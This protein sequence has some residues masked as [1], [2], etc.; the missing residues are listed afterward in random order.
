[1]NPVRLE[2][3]LE[4]GLSPGLERAGRAV[5]G[6][7]SDTGNMVR[8][9][10][11]KIT[12]A[13][14]NIRQM[15]SDIRSLSAAF[16]SATPGAARTAAGAELEAARQALKEER[17]ILRGLEGDLAR[18][19][20]AQRANSRSL[21]QQL[22][23]VREEIA[24][25]LLAYR[26][27]TDSEKQ[28]AQ[29]QELARYIDELTE[30]AGELNDTIADT[31]QAVANA[32]SDTRGLDQMAGG[33]QLVTDSFGLATAAAQ[34]LGLSEEDLIEV[35]ANLQAALVASNA[36]TSIQANLQHQSALMQG[37]AVIQARAAALAE[38][39]RTWAVGRGT[40]ATYAATAAQAVFNAVA[41]ANPYVVLAAALVTV[42][43]ALYAF[44]KGNQEAAEAEEQRQKRMEDARQ[45]QERYRQAVVDSASGQVASFLKLKR[46]WESL[47]DSFD[48]KRKFITDTKDE[49]S[50]L[51]KEISTVNDMERIFRDHTKDMLNAIVIRAELKAYET[52]I[53]SVADRMVSD[54]EKNK[55]FRYTP[56]KAGR[57]SGYGQGY[58][59]TGYMAF[60]ELTQEERAAA[61]SHYTTEAS[62]SHG[63][64]Y[65]DE[66]GARIINEMRRAAGNQAALDRQEI[67]RKA[68]E[69]EI[70]GY[71][72]D[73]FHLN[74]KLDRLMDGMPGKT[75]NP[76]TPDGRLNSS[77]SGGADNRVENE[78]K[79]AEELRRL[80]WENEQD[81]INQLADG[82]E[83]RRRLIALDYEKELAEIEQRK[84]SFA[85][86]NNEAGIK[87]VN[88]DGLTE[89]QQEE[90]DRAGELAVKNRDKSLR[91]IRVLEAQHMQEY[92]KEY[93]TY[94]Q[95]RLALSEEYDR[96]IAEASDQWERKS[97]EK[98]KTSALQNL[99][100]EAIRQSVDW[101]SVFG[102][103]GTM[104]RDQ[105]EPTIEKL[106]TIS[107][108]EEF[109]ETDLEDQQTLYELI[110]KLEEANTSW[111]NGIFKKLG[112]D[113]TSYQTAMRGYI[114]AQDKE[115]TATEA[116]AGAKERLAKAEESGDTA[117]IE[118]AKAGV[119]TATDNLTEASGKVQEFGADVQDASNSLQTSTTK[120][121]NMFNTLVSSLSGLKSGT[122]QGVGESLMGL[123]KLFNNS[124]VTNAVGGALSKGLSK[125]LGN[126][127]IGKSVA[128]ALGNS[129]L[130][131]SIISGVLSILD[132]LKDGIGPLITNLTDTVLGAV[133]GII[134]NLN[135]IN[136]GK[137]VGKSLY[138]NVTGVLTG[139]LDKITFGHSFKWFNSSNE[140]EVQ[141]A[142]DKLTERNT[143]LQGAIEKLTDEIKAGK[144]SKSVEAY[145]EAR[146]L[147]EQ[148]N[149]N[150]L[151]MAQEQ[152]RYHDSHHSF[153]YYWEGFTPEQ[154]ARLSAQMGRQWDGSLWSLSPEE[155]AMLRENADMW[156]QILQTGKGGYGEQVAVKLEEYIAQAGKLEELTTQL[157]EGLTGM[158]F[159]SMYSSFIDQ[160]MDM[161]AAAE[162]FADNISEY[163]MRAMLSN[164]IGELFYDD[165]EGW[166]R[167]F[168]EAMESGGLDER[169]M[170][171]LSEEYMGFVEEAIKL[172][173]S[174]AAATGYGQGD[175]GGSGQS[176][177]A[178][179]FNVMSQDQG[180][181]LEGLFVSAQG[182]LANIDIAMED[183]A[184]KMSAAESF[185]ARIA[186]NTKDNADSAKEIK[187][188]LLKIAKDGIRLK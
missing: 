118:A 8:D 66:E 30:K 105:L 123:D 180:T 165:L 15:E 92:L 149:A 67:A 129:G 4:D 12:E 139:I 172:R 85:T 173:D 112:D 82:A 65:I 22:R 37:V 68:A 152:A 91:E 61:G 108:T 20:E 13:R 170:A 56:V 1:M 135:V 19:N 128:E 155:M 23:E 143:A 48:K 83:R 181:K 31:S 87:D 29:G 25:L 156:Q 33:L 110:A 159:D 9:L 114:D 151:A 35:Q 96:K 132:M 162:D 62:G 53:Q 107:R 3:F 17:D 160:L 32:A 164:K 69:N 186:E 178:G 71:V 38:D 133:S 41:R 124:A 121:N 63:M 106:K 49:W 148:R 174:L 27:L 81:E 171:A 146:D 131:G 115:R 104:F 97:L 55:T 163:F 169:E 134:E 103:F 177:R 150:Y 57:V 16:E 24:T 120:V 36:L 86:L 40:V 145:R 161:D 175:S 79:V 58:G 187:E 138:D 60:Q 45:E 137:Q 179:S 126:S 99:E 166:W 88:T 11:G 144:G 125:L 74:E 176:G 51:G 39:A 136:L 157:Y 52:R 140:K 90:I 122:L 78:R 95:R 70:S 50:E 154:I 153:N 116:L 127:S 7:S 47:G 73:M 64:T 109:R 84:A 119:Q 80:R 46:E 75:V 89:A 158:T 18:A 72:D 185:L 113:L 28:T 21:R 6:L 141:E 93:G 184:A 117:G 167:K 77:S 94:Q 34:A 142:I 100:I 130:V 102:D 42:V 188:L 59:L 2:I 147:Q 26:S 168:G 111:D 76:E 10:R 43:G 98:E 183:V 182:H 5:R 14:G 54:I 44:S 101:G